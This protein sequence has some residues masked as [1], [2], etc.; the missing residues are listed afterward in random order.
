[1]TCQILF[2]VTTSKQKVQIP[3]TKIF[4]DPTVLQ[5]SEKRPYPQLASIGAHPNRSQQI[6]I[7]E[8]VKSQSSPE[9]RAKFGVSISYN[10]KVLLFHYF[11]IS[12]KVKFSYSTVPISPISNLST[13]IK[14]LRCYEKRV[15]ILPDDQGI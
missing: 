5:N 4:Y 1:M 7:F 13:I 11:Q 12:G 14:N 3:K 8:Y 9:V 2:P 6:K 15:V 10:K